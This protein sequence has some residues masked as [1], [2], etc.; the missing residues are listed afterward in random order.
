MKWIVPAIII[1]LVGGVLDE[2]TDLH[3]VWCFIIGVAAFLCFIFIKS[4]IITGSI[5]KQTKAK[6]KI[7][8]DQN[9]NMVDG[10]DE[11]L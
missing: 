1:G 6:T 7:W 2:V 3:K 10:S 4:I 8:L 5:M 9:N 11:L